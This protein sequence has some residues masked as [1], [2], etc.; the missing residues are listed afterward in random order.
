[1]RFAD[2][3]CAV[4]NEDDHGC[5]PD[6]GTW[7]TTCYDAIMS[8]VKKVNPTIVG[9]GPEIFGASGEHHRSL[10]DWPDRWAVS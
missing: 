10:S 1:M 9:V 6:D 8:E 3:I 5:Q 7:Y 4:L 2:K